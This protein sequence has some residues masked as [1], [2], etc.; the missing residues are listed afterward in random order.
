MSVTIQIDDQRLEAADNA[1]VLETARKAGI[2]IPTLCYHP[3]LKPSGSCKL[4]AVEIESGG[5]RSLVMLSCVLRV[6]E[7]MVIRT[8]SEAVQQ[9]RVKAFKRLIQMAPQAQRLHDLAEQ[10]S[11]ALPVVHSRLQGDRGPGG[12]ANGQAGRPPAGGAGAGPLR[13][14]RH[15]RQPLP[16]ARYQGD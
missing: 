3:A 11:I 9:A 12:A 16:D 8:T 2:H 10:E 14:M 4:C 13:G 5:G 6:K 1:S 15:L 7:G